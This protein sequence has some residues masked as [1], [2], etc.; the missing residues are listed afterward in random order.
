[1]N[2]LVS[3]TD[4]ANNAQTIGHDAEKYCV[5]HKVKSH[6]FIQSVD[7]NKSPINNLKMYAHHGHMTW[8][9]DLPEY[10]SCSRSLEISYLRREQYLVTGNYV[11]WKDSIIDN[12]NE[13]NINRFAFAEVYSYM[14]QTPLKHL[15]TD[16]KVRANVNDTLTF[17]RL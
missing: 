5:K 17:E 3:Y 12:F 16:Y 1:M 4:L 11:N 13:K 15:F 14:R 6:K 9:L 2:R 8:V 7:P 10:Y